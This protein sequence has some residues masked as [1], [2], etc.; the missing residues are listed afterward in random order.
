[1]EEL[2]G[3]E[4]RNPILDQESAIQYSPDQ[5]DRQWRLLTEAIRRDILVKPEV[6]DIAIS[7]IASPV[8]ESL[9]QNFLDGFSTDDRIAQ[10][11]ERYRDKIGNYLA[12]APVPE[13]QIIPDVKHAESLRSPES[14]VE[15]L[16]ALYGA[17]TPAFYQRLKE[18]VES[19]MFLCGITGQEKLML[20]QRYRFARDVKLLALQAEVLRFG[21]TIQINDRGEAVLPSGTSISVN[22]EDETRRREL[23][24]P[25]NWEK[26]RQLKD[27][28]YEIQVGSSKYILK[29]RKT[30]RHTDTKKGGHISGLTSLEEFQTAQHFQDYGVQEQGNIKVNWENPVATVTFPDGFQ[31]T[32]FEYQ[33]GLLNENM[34]TPAL[35]QKVLEHKE[36]FEDEF[37]TV[38]A[39]AQRFKDHPR[40]LVFEHG[41]TE[42]GLKAIF[43]WMRLR[44]KPVPE[45]TFEDF[46]KIKAFRMQRQAKSLMEEVVIRNGYT[47]SDLDGYAYKINP[48]DGRTQLEIFGFDFEYFSKIDQ[49]EIER[50]I[51]RRKAYD[52]E[53]DSVHAIGFLYWGDCTSVTRMQR[54]GYFAMLAAEGLFQEQPEY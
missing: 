19:G 27:R 52:K 7:Y 54:A 44:K 5:M 16:Q 10:L 3:I 38:R 17:D 31:F 13:D 45:L 36:R 22:V 28:V 4:R 6:R 43:R 29:E 49:N 40:V 33:D 48:Q 30:A 26:R 50:R 24:N 37:A 51:K 39:M 23:L 8:D 47:N 42:S 53:F 12:L 20:V 1:M 11:R 34:V 32:V 15:M 21:K 41:R 14:T 9:P 46:A 35:A 2:D 25:Q 18:N